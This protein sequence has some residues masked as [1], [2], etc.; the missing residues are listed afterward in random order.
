MYFLLLCLAMATR[1]NAD[2]QAPVSDSHLNSPQQPVIAIIMDDLGDRR[3]NDLRA[4]KLPGSVTYSFLP[5][6]PFTRQL[7][8][9]A[10]IDKKEIML[11]A[12]MES[13]DG[14]ATGPGSLLLNMSEQEFLTTLRSALES[15]PHVKGINNH[16]GSLL[17]RHPGYM[18][19][20]M[21][22]LNHGKGLFFVD[23][24]TT[25]ATVA[26]LV[27]DE[28]GV[29]N[30]KRDVFLDNDRDQAS[31]KKSF[32]HLVSIARRKGSAIAICHPYPETIN[33]LK[34]ILPALKG[35]GIKLVSVSQL[36]RL[37]KKRNKTWQLSLSR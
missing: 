1:A 11:H 4:V 2:D 13:I 24:R 8:E 33:A 20:V 37:Q 14:K 9:I 28:N 18:Q 36:I 3:A 6:A 15:V 27:A 12:P 23:S 25:D 26:R 35:M 29:P 30:A 7:A 21:Q 16:M 22:E 19:W 31:I 5:H 32:D 17:T 10:Y 34:N